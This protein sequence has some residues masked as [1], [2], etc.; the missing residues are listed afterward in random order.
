MNPNVQCSEERVAGPYP[1][2]KNHF[3]NYL[4]A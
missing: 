1:Q 4:I 3:K 2:L